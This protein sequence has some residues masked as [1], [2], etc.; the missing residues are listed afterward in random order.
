MNNNIIFISSFSRVVKIKIILIQEIEHHGIPHSELIGYRLSVIK[1][2]DKRSRSI[3][4]PKH[5]VM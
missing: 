5:I 2:P 1:M 4:G 3:T